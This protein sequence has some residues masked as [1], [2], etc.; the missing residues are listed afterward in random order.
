MLH[1]VNTTVFVMSFHYMQ[2]IFAI[3]PALSLASISYPW[4]EFSNDFCGCDIC[5]FLFFPN[6]DEHVTRTID[7][8][9]ECSVVTLD[10]GA[11]RVCTVP[12][13][14]S[15]GRSNVC[16][17][18]TTECSKFDAYLQRPGESRIKMA[19]DTSDADPD[20]CVIK[21]N[22]AWQTAMEDDSDNV[23]MVVS[24][25]SETTITHVPCPGLNRILDWTNGTHVGD[26]DQAILDENNCTAGIS[27]S[28]IYLKCY[29]PNPAT[30]NSTHFFIGSNSDAPTESNC[31]ATRTTNSPPLVEAFWPIGTISECVDSNISFHLRGPS[32]YDYDVEYPFDVPSMITTEGTFVSFSDNV[33]CTLQPYVEPSSGVLSNPIATIKRNCTVDGEAK[34]FSSTRS[35]VLTYLNDDECTVDTSSLLAGQYQLVHDTSEAVWSNTTTFSLG[36]SEFRAAHTFSNV[37]FNFT[38]RLSAVKT[39]LHFFG[40]TTLASSWTFH[41]DF[42]NSS[43][44]D[45]VG[46]DTASIVEMKATFKTNEFSSTPKNLNVPS[47]GCSLVVDDPQNQFSLA[48]FGGLD[49]YLASMA[50]ESVQVVV[51]FELTTSFKL[52]ATARRLREQTVENFKPYATHRQTHVFTY[53]PYYHDDYDHH[54]DDDHWGWMDVLLF[55]VSIAV[56]AAI[57]WKLCRPSSGTNIPPYYSMV[58]SQK[59]NDGIRSTPSVVTRLKLR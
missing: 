1:F 53:N 43:L 18:N 21:A 54:D 11:R 12:E 42:S 29:V 41:I 51:T 33:Q 37:G 2:I 58:V 57:G 17:Q 15:S 7:N 20:V 4:T 55:V 34:V 8:P 38:N 45:I 50:T 14:Y 44:S 31:S 49:D 52:C 32:D 19:Y 16:L 30:W 26:L 46:I 22:Q 9:D 39:P 23:V 56:V 3:L 27:G 10:S 5:C 59:P 6:I 48:Q 40:N 35:F 13:E 24:A 47:G 28:E 36:C 25:P